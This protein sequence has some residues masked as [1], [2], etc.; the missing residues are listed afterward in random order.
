[1]TATSH[2]KLEV[3]MNRVN[4]LN[5]QQKEIAR[6]LQST[7]DKLIKQVLDMGMTHLLSVDVAKLRRE[8]YNV[9]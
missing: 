3:L 1:M 6:E 2:E 8:L 5:N 4:D 7:K 9:K